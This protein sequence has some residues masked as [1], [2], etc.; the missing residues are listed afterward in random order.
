MTPVPTMVLAAMFAAP[1]TPMSEPLTRYVQAR[2]AEFNEIPAERKAQL[3]P[4][5]DYIRAQ[6]TAARPVKLTF[7]CTHNS[8]RSHLSQV[9]ARTAANHYGIANVETYSGGTEATA[10]NP[11]AVAALRRAGFEIPELLEAGNPKYEVK[12]HSAAEPMVCFSKRFDQSPNPASG[13]AAVMTCTQA[14]RACPIVAGADA[15]ISIPYEDPKAFDNT[16]DEARKYDE[17]TAQIA[18]ELL[19]VFSQVA[20]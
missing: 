11:R 6:V 20:K 17:R 5:A 9:W 7:I 15:R 8:R 2:E 13:F 12:W 16:P 18:R 10:F 19:Y 14:D 3:T 4:L 1:S